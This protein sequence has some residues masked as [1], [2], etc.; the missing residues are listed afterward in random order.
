MTEHKRFEATFED[1][2]ALSR[3]LNIQKEDVWKI[4]EGVRY[5]NRSE[6]AMMIHR[7]FRDG[8]VSRDGAPATGGGS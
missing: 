4:I 3:D 2:C 1:A 5:S 7:F 6:L 8:R